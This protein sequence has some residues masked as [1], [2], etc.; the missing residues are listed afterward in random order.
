MFMQRED[1]ENKFY[2][3]NSLATDVRNERRELKPARAKQRMGPAIWIAACV[4]AGS[5]LW[6]MAALFHIV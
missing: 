6:L 4:L 2:Y 5:V 1:R 3:M